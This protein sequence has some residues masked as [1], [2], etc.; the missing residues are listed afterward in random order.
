MLLT[1]RFKCLLYQNWVLL[2]SF[3]QERENLH[4]LPLSGNI[5]PKTFMSRLLVRPQYHFYTCAW[6]SVPLICCGSFW[7]ILLQET[8][9]IPCIKCIIQHSHF[10]CTLWV[11]DHATV[12]WVRGTLWK[13]GCLT[14]TLSLRQLCETAKLTY[15]IVAVFKSKQKYHHPKRC[16][17]SCSGTKTNSS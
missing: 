8:S 3:S 11:G 9:N 10:D 17:Q 6:L 13:L 16:I 2:C 5:W 1:F 4:S 15:K 7:S 12:S 14:S